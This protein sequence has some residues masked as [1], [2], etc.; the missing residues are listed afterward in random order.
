MPGLVLGSYR[1][2]MRTPSVV[3]CAAAIGAS[4]ISAKGRKRRRPRDQKNVATAS[5]NQTRVKAEHHRQHI[6]LES[7]RQ[8]AERVRGGLNGAL[9][10]EI[11]RERSRALDKTNGADRPSRR[12][13]NM[14]SALSGEPR[15]GRKRKRDLPHDVFEVPRVWKVDPLGADVRDV[16][17]ATSLLATAC[18]GRRRIAIDARRRDARRRQLRNA[19]RRRLGL[20]RHDLFG[21]R[22]RR[23]LVFAA[24]RPRARASRRRQPARPVPRR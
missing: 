11:E 20:H 14:I 22:A 5:T 1:S 9:R 12:I 15:G 17:A 3:S 7:A 13:R 16:G 23:R 18:H 2:P 24:A 4:A 19:S 10:F 6:V 21:L 8:R